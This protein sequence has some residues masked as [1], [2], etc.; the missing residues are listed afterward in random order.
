MGR[1]IALLFK[2]Q[3]HLMTVDQ[4]RIEDVFLAASEIPEAERSAFLDGA[5]RADADLRAAVDR[6]LAA[7]ADPAT[8]FKPMIDP[9]GPV[10]T[11][12]PESTIAFTAQ[13]N[14]GTVLAGRYTLLEEIGEG[15]MGTVWMARQAEPVKR[16]VAVKLIKPG[17]DS[18]VVLARFEAERQALALMDHPNIARV[19]DGGLSSDGHPF[20]VMDLVKGVPITQFCDARKLTPR[21]RLELFVPVCQAIQHAHQ[22]GIIHRDI[23]PSNVL[24]ALYDDRAV[25]KVIDFGVAKAIGQSLTEITLHTGFGTVVGTPQYMSPEQ[26]MFNN[27]DID[28][29]SDLYSLGVLLYELLAGSPPFMKKDLEKAGMLEMLR[30]V[31]EEEPQRPS[32]R[33]STADALPSI[34]ANR[35]TEPKKLTGMLRNELDW[36]VMKALEKDRTRR[37]ETA[38]GF[39]SDVLRY[40]SGEPVLAVPPSASYRMRKFARKNRGP[41][42]ATVAILLLLFGGVAANRWEAVRAVRAE[43][44]AREAEKIASERADHE[45]LAKQQAQ[46]ARGQALKRLSQIEKSNAVL[47]SVFE[48]LN[49][50]RIK[51]STEPLEAVLAQRLVKAAKELEGEA[52]G[53][54]L[55]V[56]TL[57]ENLGEALLSL[58]YPREAIPLLIKSRD[59]RASLV[60]NE[61]PETLSSMSC[62][63]LCYREQKQ[64]DQALALYQTIL[65]IR[66][67]NNPPEHPEI[68]SST[69]LLGWCYWY[70]RKYEEALPLFEEV[71]NVRVRKDGLDQVRTV[72]SLH[73]LALC[74]LEMGKYDEAMPRLK[75]IWKLRKIM[76]AANHPDTLSTMNDLAVCYQRSG[77]LE[78]AL[79]LFQETLKLRQERLGTT[80]P[81]TFAIMD[82]L[83]QCYWDMGKRDEGVSLLEKLLMLRKERLGEKHTD[84]LTTMHELGFWYRV[85]GKLD[86]AIPL[87]RETV[88]LRKEVLGPENVDTITSLTDLA[89]CHRL[90]G[91]LD[92][93]LPLFQEAAFVVEELGFKPKCSSWVIGELIAC[94]EQL[95][96]VEQSSIWQRKLLPLV[97]EQSGADSL[98]YANLLASLGSN[99][100]QLKKWSDADDALSKSLSIS[101]KKEPEAWTTFNAQSMRGEALLRLGK[102]TEATPLIL[103][104]YEGMK[105]RKRMIP[106]PEKIRLFQGIERMV[107]LH[108]AIGNK[109]SAAKWQREVPLKAKPE[110]NLLINGSFEE[111][112][113]VSNYLALDAGS[114]A[115]PGWV[116]TRGQIDVVG[117]YWVAASGKRSIDLHG[118][119]GFGGVAQKFKTEKGKHYQ[120]VFSLAGS[121]EEVKV[122]RTGV[123][124]AGKTQEFSFDSTG[125]TRSDM[126]WEKMV[127]EFEAIAEE[128][129]LE[130]YTLETT[131]EFAGPVIDDVWVLPL[132]AKR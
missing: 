35:G 77:N 80:H 101:E 119:P 113:E 102:V 68:L 109:D 42:L 55:V 91:Q 60:G 62:L 124:A 54:P 104:G 6:L 131:D 86:L 47:T 75:E 5:C 127:W 78:Q 63:A 27:M 110:D 82:N 105:E 56:A 24:V 33:L 107:A 121:G 10:T 64:F 83:A 92:V 132:P 87:M 112:P 8:I 59:T 120:V 53:E 3:E 84:T 81:H 12:S 7:H 66:K 57:Q 44:E 71:Y 126:G 34:A 18:K 32:T 1:F 43:G 40:L 23:K 76:L 122:K 70:M 11:A 88:K 52:V 31:R 14:V 65:K 45:Q 125:T 19:L 90:K 108:E 9:T 95:Q 115:M 94:S 15:G 89:F 51:E 16:F 85:N 114:T 116:V 20:F 74:Y 28:T 99:L 36:I 69:I 4:N 48:D 39:A 38:N 72:D 50:Y 29:R 67:A 17:M 26:A 93:A 103:K 41:L 61:A 79:S 22:K 100:L 21:Q 117:Y 130:I 37:Y 97:R 123:S 2:S 25:P 111:G 128:T 106:T 118:S 30:V 98:E 46:E 129:T 49:V 96:T 13:V 73:S 58:G